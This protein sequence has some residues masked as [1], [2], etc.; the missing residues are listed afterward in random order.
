M[1]A[2]WSWE[3]QQLIITHNYGEVNANTA[4]PLYTYMRNV[5]PHATCVSSQA[6]KKHI[7]DYYCMSFVLHP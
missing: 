4:H 5:L 1:A 3:W 6:C 7:L 2:E